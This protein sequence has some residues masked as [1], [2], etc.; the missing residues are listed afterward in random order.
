ME[1]IKKIVVGEKIEKISFVKVIKV[2]YNEK[3]LKEKYWKNIVYNVL[4]NMVNEIFE[5]IN[6]LFFIV[7]KGFRRC[8]S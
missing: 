7:R 4:R 6:V 2:C 1:F 3:N 5:L 8:Y